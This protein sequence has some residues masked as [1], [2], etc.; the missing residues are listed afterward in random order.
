[1]DKRIGKLWYLHAREYYS[2]IENEGILPFAAK[3]GDLEDIMLN[4]TGQTEKDTQGMISLIC[5]I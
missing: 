4:D 2:A 5:G 3:R 1:M